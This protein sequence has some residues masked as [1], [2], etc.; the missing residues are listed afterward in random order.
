MRTFAYSVPKHV[1]DE[2]ISDVKHIT[3]LEIKQRGY[4]LDEFVED[5]Y[6]WETTYQAEDTM[7]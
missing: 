3:F 2:F 6:A 7:S 5:T 4:T 1:K